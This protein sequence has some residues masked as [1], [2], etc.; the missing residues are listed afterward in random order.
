MAR[1]RVVWVRSPFAAAGLL[2]IAISGDT[3][4]LL[5]IWGRVLLNLNRY[6]SAGTPARPAT[7]PPGDGPPVG[8]APDQQRSMLLRTL[9]LLLLHLW[10]CAI[11]LQRAPNAALACS[12]RGRKWSKATTPRARSEAEQHNTSRL[13][14]AALLQGPLVRVRAECSRFSVLMPEDRRRQNSAPRRDHCSTLQHRFKLAPH[15]P[16]CSWRHSP[17]EERRAAGTV[18]QRREWRAG[19]RLAQPLLSHQDRCCSSCC[20]RRAGA[21]AVAPQ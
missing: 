3:Y 15:S 16:S 21:G 17:P 8:C 9:M 4:V 1:S 18:G 2:R 13:S 12:L 14:C 5:Y 7:R 19:E 11:V 20:S 10:T 6:G